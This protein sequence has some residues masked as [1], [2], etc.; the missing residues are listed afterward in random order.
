MVQLIAFLEDVF[1]RTIL[2]FSESPEHKQRTIVVV[3]K[4]ILS[5]YRKSSETTLEVE[6]IL[7]DF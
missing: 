2:L 5:S 6:Q 1:L 4:Q 7:K 3:P